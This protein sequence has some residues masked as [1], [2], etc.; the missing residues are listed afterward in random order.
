MSNLCKRLPDS[1]PARSHDG[2]GGV[3]DAVAVEQFLDVL[4]R[5]LARRHVKTYFDKSRY[6]ASSDSQDPVKLRRRRGA[7]NV[8]KTAAE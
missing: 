4:A 8:E 5:L 2:A 7:K 6:F 3:W 1:T